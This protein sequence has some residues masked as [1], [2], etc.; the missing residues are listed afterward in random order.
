MQAEIPKKRA[1]NS[2]LQIHDKRR[3]FC[4]WHTTPMPGYPAFPAQTPETSLISLQRTE[5]FEDTTTCMKRGARKHLH[6]HC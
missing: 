4:Y 3:S 1:V 6:Q 2:D 5:Q